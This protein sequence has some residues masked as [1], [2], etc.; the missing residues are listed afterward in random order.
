M[1]FTKY[2]KPQLLFPNKTYYLFIEKWHSQRPGHFKLDP[3]H[4]QQKGE[5]WCP[6]WCW[7]SPWGFWIMMLGTSPLSGLRH[8]HLLFGRQGVPLE[9]PHWG[10][11]CKR[12]HW[13]T[14]C[15]KPCWKPLLQ[16]PQDFIG[17]RSLF[18]V[19]FGRLYL[20]VLLKNLEGVIGEPRVL[21]R[22]QSIEGL[23]EGPQ[24][25]LIERC[26]KGPEPPNSRIHMAFDSAIGIPFQVRFRL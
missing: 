9:R 21:A 26:D 16:G 13:G 8:Y 11:P 7:L 4:Q 12:P 17:W 6:A 20:E 5:S 19:L 18:E 25:S 3:M 1:L 23:F 10:T 14:T 24:T 22:F 15:K 2:V